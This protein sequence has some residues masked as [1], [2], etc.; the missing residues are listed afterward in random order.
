M[1]PDKPNGTKVGQTIYSLS[2]SST[3]RLSLVLAL[4]AG[5]WWM[6]TT[7]SGLQ[8]DIESLKELMTIRLDHIDSNHT[9]RLGELEIRVRALENAR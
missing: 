7:V 2:E 8:N 9:R 4:G 6:A 1:T 3:V 5:I